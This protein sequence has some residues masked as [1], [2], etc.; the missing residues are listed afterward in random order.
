M[1]ELGMNEI[2]TLP[3]TPHER[4]IN[5]Q[6]ILAVKNVVFSQYGANYEAW[7]SED[8][9]ILCFAFLLHLA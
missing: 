2:W 1:L 3:R 5:N 8:N 4:F 7:I 6:R 9:N